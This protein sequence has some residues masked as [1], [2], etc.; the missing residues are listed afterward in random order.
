MGAY[1]EGGVGAYLEGG[2]GARGVS[3]GRG[4]YLMGAGRI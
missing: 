3:D 4:A 1:L 2:V